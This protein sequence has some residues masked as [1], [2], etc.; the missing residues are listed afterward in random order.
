MELHIL[1]CHVPCSSRVVVGRA[2]DSYSIDKF[3]LVIVVNLLLVQVGRRSAMHTG[4]FLSGMVGHKRIIPYDFPLIITV[5]IIN[6]E[7]IN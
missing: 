7:H 5:T 1:L 4:I 6:Y 2:L 3:T